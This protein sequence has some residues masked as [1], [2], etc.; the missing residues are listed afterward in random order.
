VKLSGDVGRG[1]GYCE[2]AFLSSE[3]AAMLDVVFWFVEAFFIPP[4]LA[5]RLDNLG[6]VCLGEGIVVQRPEDLLLASFGLLNV[7][8]ELLLL[9]LPLHLLLSALVGALVVASYSLCTFFAWNLAFFSAFFRSFSN[10]L[11]DLTLFPTPLPAL[12][13]PGISWVV[14]SV[15]LREAAFSA[16]LAD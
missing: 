15:T 14:A 4:V 10:S 11:S 6:D 12:S 1:H 5:R 2:A 8:V 9:S 13:Q 16:I 3:L 7:F